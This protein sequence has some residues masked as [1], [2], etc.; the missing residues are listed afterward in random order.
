MTRDLQA[1]LSY[2]WAKSLDTS[3]DESVA[4]LQAPLN[5]LSP[6]SDRGPSSFD[7]R[8]GFTGSASY[9]LPAPS[10]R[11]LARAVLGGFALDSVLRLRTAAPVTVVTGAT[12]SALA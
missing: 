3:S 9:E 2:T 11:G 4:N 5:R 12:R 8:H 6:N 1:L 7:I 10:S